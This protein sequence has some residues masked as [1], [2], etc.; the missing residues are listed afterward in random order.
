MKIDIL[1]LFS[2]KNQIAVKELTYRF[3]VSVKVFITSR[4]SIIPSRILSNANNVG[5]LTAFSCQNPTRIMLG[6]DDELTIGKVEIAIFFFSPSSVSHES[7]SFF[8]FFA[9]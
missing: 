9:L 2:L 7:F 4:K 8:P 6:F 3:F 1:Q 5:R